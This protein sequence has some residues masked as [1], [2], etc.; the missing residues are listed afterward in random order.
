MGK[1]SKLKDEQISIVRSVVGEDFSEMDIIRAL[2]MAADDP[3][4]AI[5]I[6]FDTPPRKK[7]PNPLPPPP[8]PPPPP[9]GGGG[10][11]DSTSSSRKPITDSDTA[12]NSQLPKVADNDDWWLVG[13]SE[14]A[15]LST[16]K[17]RRIKAG[18]KVTFSFPPALGERNTKFPS[19]FQ[20][21]GRGRSGVA[22]S[23]SEIVRFSMEEYGEI[24]RI[25]NEWA[26]CLSPLV[27]EKKIRIEGICKSA[28][29]V[30]GIMDTIILSVRVYINSSMFQKHHQTSMKP[31]SSSLEVSTLHPLPTL[32]R[33]LGLTP[34]K[35]ASFLM[36][37]FFFFCN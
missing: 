19:K 4:A 14:L 22:A 12:T 20:L 28:P 9:P 32:F 29:Q 23:C 16:C 11:D 8:P 33:L 27:K 24:G 25:P 34:F 10:H 18:D 31:T 37:S 15:G 5:N 7:N 30:L 35:K 26:R 36:H 3:S 21:S 6:I 13:N 2:H 1:K 17:G